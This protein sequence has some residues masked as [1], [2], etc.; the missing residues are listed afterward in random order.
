MMYGALDALSYLHRAIIE[1]LYRPSEESYDYLVGCY[2]LSDLRLSF[3]DWQSIQ[4]TAALQS[5]EENI[6]NLL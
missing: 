5:L 3:P 4:T 1:Q 2:A 6:L